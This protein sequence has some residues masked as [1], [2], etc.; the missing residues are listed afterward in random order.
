MNFKGLALSLAVLIFSAP[1][2]AKNVTNGSINFSM[3]DAGKKY[4]QLNGDWEFYANQTFT[5]L[6]GAK[7]KVDFIEAPAPWTKK[8]QD[9]PVIPTIGCHTYRIVVTGLRP[10]Y[11][12]A[13]FSRRN[14]CNSAM[15]YSNG[16]FLLECGK[17][18]RHKEN[19]KAAQGPI[20]ARV[21]SNENGMIELVVQVSNFTGGQSGIVTPIFF[22]EEVAIEKMFQ[23]MMLTNAA[24]LGGLLFILLMNIAFWV[25]D[26]TKIVHLYFSA[27]I[28]F[29]IMRQ[30]FL[31]FNA[32]T[33]LQLSPPFGLQFKLQ[34]LLVFSGAIFALLNSVDKVFA[35]KRPLL[36]KMIAAV[37]FSLMTFFICLPE[38]VSLYMLNAAMLWAAL[39]AVYSIF[40]FCAALKNSQ[41]KAAIFN[42]FYLVIAIPVILD[43]FLGL[44]WTSWLLYLSEISLM[45]M[46]CGDV[47]NIAAILEIM[48][49][50]AILLKNEAS[51]YHLSIRRFVP[52]VL[53]KLSEANVF[54]NL[55][56]GSKIEEPMTIMKVGFKVI[57]PDNTQINLRDTFES[58]GF[59]SATIIDQINK[60]DGSTISVSTQGIS[61][62]FR[63][64]PSDAIN[65]AHEIRDLIQNINARRAEDYYPCVTF[66][67]S[68]HRC[69]VLLGIVGDR[70]H[71]DFTMIS[72]GME[73]TEKM[74]N[75]GYAMNIPALISEPTYQTLEPDVQNKLKLLGKIHFSEFARPIGL[76]G[77]ISSEEEESSLE[78]L[79]ES[80][81]ITQ[82]NADKYINY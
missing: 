26:K 42:F 68:I 10:N 77:F 47:I 64:N 49:K 43:H 44:F 50:K 46:I 32:L 21:S 52:R 59:Y 14:P 74:L 35:A 48:Q 58:M 36:D 1:L 23:R 81:F 78:N 24:L 2:F 9:K 62:L 38:S 51:K 6:L 60:N 5:S 75:L 19:Y 29:L 11:E 65:S 55:E 53:T 4:V 34:N 63:S 12:Y 16:R 79:D 80:P 27:L 82:V 76:Y 20:F 31:N 57:S 17:F 3:S 37:G 73:V 28:F 7:L 30:S 70:T 72:S 56:I 15:F 33:F 69:D 39:Y 71:I 66:N 22:G 13:I 40:R 45:V 67:I 41:Y 25:F 18:S 8:R 54:G 61:A